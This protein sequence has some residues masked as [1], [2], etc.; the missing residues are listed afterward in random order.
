MIDAPRWL[1]Y[2]LISTL[3]FVLGCLIVP[4]LS[5]AMGAQTS[6]TG[7]NATRKTNS[8]QKNAKLINYGLSLS[9]GSLLTTALYKM[10][11]PM[12]GS[13][14]EKLQIFGGLLV[15]ICVSLLLNYIV[16]AFA[17]ESLVHCAHGNQDIHIDETG[18]T[19][20]IP[21]NNND[22]I[23]NVE[24]QYQDE[25]VQPLL[26][27]G[28]TQSTV[29]HKQSLIDFISKMKGTGDCRD[30]GTCR[31]SYLA[32][33]I[34]FSEN[35]GSSGQ[36]SET[37]SA[38]QASVVAAS[39]ADRV[40]GQTKSAVCSRAISRHEVET[41]FDERSTA[42]FCLGSGVHCI[43]NNIEYDL[44]NLSVYRKHF[45]KG[46]NSALIEDKNRI[47]AL[48]NSSS[49][50]TSSL[51]PHD[52]VQNITVVDTPDAIAGRHSHE[53]LHKKN[54]GFIN[55]KTASHN[56]HHHHLETPFSK[57]LSIGLQT[58]LVL[59]LHKFPEGLI[60]YFTNQTD[61]SFG[62]SIFL[63]L[64]IHNFVEGF[65]MTLPLYSALECKSGALLISMGLGGISQPLGAV[66]GYIIFRNKPRDPSGDLKQQSGSLLSLTAGF[67]LVIGLQMFQTG[68]GFSD[69][70]H[71]HED[72]A[73]TELKRTHSSG[74]SCLKWC[75]FGCLL[76]LGSGLFS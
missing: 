31:S 22:Q 43:V 33:T 64:A 26:A 70:H 6:L 21:H 53:M 18:Q 8:E 32:P 1:I 57:L 55:V 71:H 56:H 38:N 58:C 49:S 60:M 39:A 67:L 3:L 14:A 45:L 27:N 54:Q 48:T 61:T 34:R 11:P 2:S 44:E 23:A 15:G 65:A 72:D 62:F 24:E 12:K 16:H 74:T 28:T 50:D 40:S 19:S 30:I 17:S 75:C 37:P 51:G 41:N 73:E 35:P 25:E 63:S 13:K 4:L 5:V 76:I 47:P 59:T 7:S 29:R 52:E 9:A 69:N 68:I 66:I 42:P 20:E 36:I 46:Q 10:L